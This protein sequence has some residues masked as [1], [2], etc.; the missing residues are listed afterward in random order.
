MSGSQHFDE[1]NVFVLEPNHRFPLPPKPSFHLFPS[2]TDSLGFQLGCV[3]Y[4]SH[5]FMI[6]ISNLT[7]E[8][9]IHCPVL[10]K[11]CLGVCTHPLLLE[12]P[13][14]S[15]LAHALLALSTVG[16]HRA[17]PTGMTL[18][19]SWSA[20]TQVNECTKYVY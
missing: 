2:T 13:L 8:G 4:G 5:R 1:S 7:L 15:F 10:G 19:P 20:S 16:F 9:Q 6:Y 18:V 12:L 17:G 11:S 3:S 14:V